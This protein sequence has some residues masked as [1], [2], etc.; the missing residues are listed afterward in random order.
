MQK[1]VV[2]EV[3]IETQQIVVFL[4]ER[5]AILVH[6]VDQEPGA[7]QVIP[8]SLALLDRLVGLVQMEMLVVQEPVVH[9]DPLDHQDSKVKRLSRNIMKALAVIY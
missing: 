9:L 1:F 8:V 7:Y 4:Q 3:V 6:R 2:C 5:L